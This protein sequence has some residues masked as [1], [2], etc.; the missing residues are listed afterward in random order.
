MSVYQIS[1]FINLVL[2][3]I[4][5][6]DPTKITSP[7]GILRKKNRTGKSQI[8]QHSIECK[9]L[10]ALCFDG[11]KAEEA[12]PNNQT[13]KDHFL[14]IS[15]GIVSEGV[16]SYVHHEKSGYSGQAMGELVIK[17]I[18]KTESKDSVIVLQ[19]DNTGANSSPDIRAHRVIELWLG[20]AVQ[21]PYC[22]NHGAERPFR[23]LRELFDG[24]TVGPCGTSGKIGKAMQA[25]EKYQGPFVQFER[26]PNFMPE[27]LEISA[28][29]E[30]LKFLCT[31][32]HYIA[33]GEIPDHYVTKPPPP[34][35]N[36]RWRNDC[37]RLCSVFV[38]TPDPENYPGMIEIVKWICQAYAPMVLD[39]YFEPQLYN[40]PV[41]MHA[42]LNRT[43]CCLSPELYVHAKKIILNNGAMFHPENLL[44]AGLLSKYSTPI[45]QERALEIILHARNHHKERADVRKFSPPQDH[46]IN[47]N[48]RSS[49]M[50]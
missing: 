43:K 21:R 35:N 31:F 34:H 22:L 33:T 37:T 32:V 4:G 46:Q 50:F 44:V 25:L 17:V 5:I 28:L 8:E 26:I 14:G 38:R 18:E 27:D 41:H 23:K 29:P 11:V 49:F 16:T 10:L 42:F 3:A 20:R 36:A 7:S 13:Q 6:T 9:H 48:A 39:V 15:N 30:D 2:K 40:G 19:S 47:D 24:P 1:V 12:L 45:I